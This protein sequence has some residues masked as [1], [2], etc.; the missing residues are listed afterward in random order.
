[1][2]PAVFKAV[3]FDENWINHDKI[4]IHAIYRRPILDEVGEQVHIE[5]I[6][7][8]DFT[9]GLPVRRH[10]DWVKKG[11]H[12]LTLADPKSLANKHVLQGLRVKGLNPADFIML[13]NRMVGQSPWNPQLYLASADQVERESFASLRALVERLGSD[14][15]RDVKRVD[16]PTFELPLHLRDIPPGGRAEV[17]STSIAAAPASTP[18]TP[19][20]AARPKAP[21]RHSLAGRAAKRAAK[22]AKAP[23]P[24]AP[25]G[26]PA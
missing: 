1:M 6:P 5:G 16:D 23:A 7:Q 15:V 24:A 2:Q 17:P 14:A 21:P 25:V 9:T 19:A 11:F 26:E 13:R 10:Y 8:W 20:A 3:P 22:Q 4:D 12:Y 18:V